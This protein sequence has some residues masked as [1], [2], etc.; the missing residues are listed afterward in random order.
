LREVA[1]GL[2]TLF[3]VEPSRAF[4]H[5]LRR[6][7]LVF[8]ARNRSSSQRQFIQRTAVSPRTLSS[9]YVARW[10]VAR[11]EEALVRCRNAKDSSAFDSSVTALRGE[12]EAVSDNNRSVRAV[13]DQMDDDARELVFRGKK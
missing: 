3:N 12:V 13:I 4:I 5:S 6:G 11:A 10:S 7:T 8:G 2:D 9:A 1:I